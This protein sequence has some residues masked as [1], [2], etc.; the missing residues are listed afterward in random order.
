MKQE[1]EKKMHIDEEGEEI[2]GEGE[3][4]TKYD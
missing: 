2:D 4:E 1:K 3:E